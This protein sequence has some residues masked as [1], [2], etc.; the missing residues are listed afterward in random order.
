MQGPHSMLPSAKAALI[1]QRFHRADARC[2]NPR[3][4]FAVAMADSLFE[5]LKR[6]RGTRRKRL[7]CLS[8]LASLFW[9]M[10]EEE[11]VGLTYKSL[12]FGRKM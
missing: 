12:N 3:S 1:L 6:K 8:L 4:L 7:C 2:Y 11:C 9:M 10:G 5:W